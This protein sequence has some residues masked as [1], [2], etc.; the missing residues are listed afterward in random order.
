MKESVPTLTRI[1]VLDKLLGYDKFE[2]PEVRLDPGTILVIRGE[3]GAGKTTLGLQ[4]L[5]KNLEYLRQNRQ[6]DV[7]ETKY[8]FFSL[9]TDP[10]DVLGYAQAQY[11]FFTTRDTKAS[12]THTQNPVLVNNASNSPVDKIEQEGIIPLNAQVIELLIQKATEG[13]Q[14]FNDFYTELMEHPEKINA[15]GLAVT[16]AKGLVSMLMARLDQEEITDEIH[17]ELQKGK[18]KTYPFVFID[19]VNVLVRL[20]QKIKKEES[21]ERLLLNTI[22]DTLKEIFTK[23]VIILTSEYH[24]QDSNKSS[25]V[26]ESFLCD[27]EVALFAEPVVVP[28]NYEP[29]FESP[30]GSNI[31]SL[32]APGGKS[33]QTQS[34]CRVLKSRRTPN[35][36]RRCTYDIVSGKGVEFY[37]TY[38]GDGHL[39]FFAENTRQDG[40]WKELFQQDLPLL[41]P[42]L[43]YDSFDRSSLQRTSAAQR[44][45]R[46]VPARVDMYLASFD[47]YWVNWYSE[48]CLKSNV[49]DI[50][51]QKVGIDNLF[52]RKPLLLLLN[53]IC[54][55]LTRQKEFYAFRDK[56]RERTNEFWHH[57]ENQGSSLLQ[58][59][60]KDKVVKLRSEDF[61]NGLFSVF[62]RVNS[63]KSCLEC[64]WYLQM[65]IELNDRL[66][67][68]SPQDKEILGPEG[69]PELLK[70][71]YEMVIE[72]KMNMKE[73][74]DD[75]YLFRVIG[76][77][78][79]GCVK[80]LTKDLKL[81]LDFSK[82]VDDALED[83]QRQCLRIHLAS[84]LERF[85]LAASSD[86]PDMDSV[87]N[88]RPDGTR[89]ALLNDLLK[90][91]LS[92]KLINDIL[93][94]LG[95]SVFQNIF[96]KITDDLLRIDKQNSK[97]TSKSYWFTTFAHIFINVI[98]RPM[99]Y[100]LVKPIEQS[101]LRLFGERRSEI[102]HELEKTVLHSNRPI[103]RPQRLFTSKEGDTYCS[104]PYDA[105]ISFLGYRRD[106]WDTFI[107]KLGR[108]DTQEY[109]NAIVEIING[110]DVFLGTKEANNSGKHKVNDELLKNQ[111]RELVQRQKQNAKTGIRCYPK[112]WE[113]II[114][115]YL[116]CK[117]NNRQLDFVIETRTQDTLLC[118]MLE[119]IWSCGVNFRIAPDYGIL[120]KPETLRGVLRAFYLLSLMFQNQIIPVNSTLDSNEFGRRYSQPNQDKEQP[121]DWAF[122]RHWY[123]TL[124]EV[125]SARKK[126]DKD[127]DDSIRFQWERKGAIVDIMPIPVSFATYALQGDKTRHTS[128]WGDWHLAI[129]NGTENMELGI[130]LVNNLMS[131]DRICDRAFAN[132]AIPT[133]EAFYERYG[134]TPCFNLPERK[135]IKLPDLTYNDLRDT[136]FENA[137]SR[138]QVFDFHHCM[139]ELH[140]VLEYVHFVCQRTPSGSISHVLNKSIQNDLKDK[141]KNAIEQIED[142]KESAFMLS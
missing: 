79:S 40:N 9:E 85:F 98:Y 31:L 46:Y 112:T 44:R 139:R 86:S 28:S 77:A 20:L 136:F 115:F 62:A 80:N 122:A 68:Q 2:R 99:Y 78:L 131:S 21:N 119:F 88:K 29:K 56:I 72:Q 92:E 125:L 111:V 33:I 137:K 64:L 52:A 18:V 132:S 93:N 3:P 103:H 141:I 89:N 118:I 50:L 114:A 83:A 76:D 91:P 82:S 12:V 117:K 14:T 127:D 32:M 63:K 124:I 30:L 97:T 57:L 95:K 106:I 22:L 71:A 108:R 130:D 34:F 69:I 110:Q 101:Q 59:M 45:F 140:P 42:A 10:V 16:V 13:H 126:K 128:C 41:Y 54:I 53:D 105:N 81:Q 129:I 19:S 104:I 38:P 26:S 15:T 58:V 120:K 84:F 61:A 73:I 24:Y 23:S 47:N 142:F 65:I 70:L 116:F 123:S 121:V 43:R 8:V 94:D 48:L 102:I 35:Q 27:V 134:D 135:D 5:S 39:I 96:P 66:N 51:R 138:S 4:I 109:I 36:S 87:E 1:D 17:E 113:E 25:I 37:E 7:E 6:N 100:R 75:G 90:S 133:V 11:V 60:D 55:A 49:A 67:E 107:G 74:R